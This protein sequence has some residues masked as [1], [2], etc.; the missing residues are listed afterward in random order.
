LLRY[1]L[2]QK[3]YRKG[4]QWQTKEM[5]FI[6]TELDGKPVREE[7]WE[8]LNTPSRTVYERTMKTN[9]PDEILHG[10]HL[11]FGVEF[12]RYGERWFLIVKPEWFFSFHGYNRNSFVADRIDWLKRHEWNTHVFNHFK[13]ILRYISHERPA[14]LFEKA[15]PAYPFLRLKELTALPG[16]PAIDDKDW[17]SG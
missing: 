17:L 15:A 5:L 6:F 12:R 4:I 13:F 2:Q 11:A 16:S 14:T 8:G 9:K 10:K 1:C 7:R 3:L